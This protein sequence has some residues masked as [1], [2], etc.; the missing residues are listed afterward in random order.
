MATPSPIYQSTVDSKQ[1]LYYKPQGADAPVQI[2]NPDELQS[3]AKQGLV[4]VGKP[5][6]PF[7]PPT[8][9][10]TPAAPTA[11]DTINPS[12]TGP[13]PG[14]TPNAQTEIKP[15]VFSSSK[16][17]SFYDNQ[18]SIMKP[19]FEAAQKSL[20]DVSA[21]L[22]A[23]KA[24]DYQ[25]KYKTDYAS[26]V[27]PIDTN[28]SSATQKLT[29]LDDSIRSLEDAVRAEIGGR[30]S[31]ASIQAEV[32]R[33]SKPL[34]LQRQT[35]VDQ[36]NGFNDQR[37]TALDAI[38]QG[39]DF[40]QKDFANQT[41]LLGAQRDLAQAS[42]DAFSNLVE[43]G[44]AASDKEVD[45]FRQTF[46][47]LLQQAPEV[48]RTLTEEEVG[49]IQQGFVPY[50]VMT[51]IGDT[52]NEQKLAKSPKIFGSAASGYWT[53]DQNG[54][55]TQLVP[56]STGSSGLSQSQRVTAAIKLMATDPSY[57]DINSALAAV[58]ALGG[59]VGGGGGAGGGMGG[60][61]GTSSGSPS[62]VNIGGFD[63]STY[64]TDPNHEA[65]VASILNNI[66]QFTTIDQV[67]QYIKQVAPGSPVTGEMIS[68][69]SEKYGVPWEMM[70]AMM[71]QDSNLGTAGKGART[72]NPGNVGNTDSGAER[73]YGSWQAGVDAVGNWLSKHR[74]QGGQDFVSDYTRRAQTI[75]ASKPKANQTEAIRAVS[76]LVSEGKTQEADRYLTTLA[77]DTLGETEQK[78]YDEKSNAIAALNVAAQLTN[79]PT[80][81]AGPYKALFETKAPYALIQRDPKY[82]QFRV[83]TDIG[84]AQLRRAFFGT[85]VTDNEQAS[86]AGFLI[87]ATDDMATI[88][89]KLQDLPK[90]L[91]FANDAKISKIMGTPTPKLTDYVDV[92][93][94]PGSAGASGLGSVL[95][96]LGY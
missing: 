69:A 87:N 83:F 75:M 74:A 19:Q 24:P 45:N 6:Q 13:T 95:S 39:L 3:L 28:I 82:A 18:F 20:A 11:P 9:A 65:S 17:S 14:A 8:G 31:E 34:L 56:P 27:A 78:S 54:Q 77:Y 48:L 43:K 21:A 42:I 10:P 52:I 5:Y 47:T 7:T 57:P 81:A 22:G 30:A 76:K 38:T 79:D 64:A 89:Q 96:E 50:S 63:I 53:M 93:R 90:I 86:S 35:V 72:F 44:A 33:R 1:R 26:T 37:K 70:V 36:I 68:K 71:Q 61:G 46:T 85:A 29:G 23:T 91:Q 59:G 41:T 49:Q 60:G 94:V 2:S 4:E 15:G 73:N 51:K 25:G 62:K 67:D 80:L 92:S 88:K 16:L 12:G 40:A 55:P 32:A 84:Q 58:D 66:G